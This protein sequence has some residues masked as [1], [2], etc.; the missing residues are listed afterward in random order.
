[1]HGRKV[2]C[3]GAKRLKRVFQVTDNRVF[4]RPLGRS[5]RSFAHSAHSLRS[6]P[7]CYAPCTGSLIH[8]AHSLVG[9]L[10]FLNMCSHCYCVPREQTRFS[11]SLETRPYH[12]AGDHFF[13]ETISFLSL[14]ALIHVS[15]IAILVIFFVDITRACI[16][17]YECARA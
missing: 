10:K 9:Q 1:M 5:L 12:H 7:Q 13:I 2:K 8:F 17:A 14:I 4:N 16:A 3:N 6:A 11:S 15:V